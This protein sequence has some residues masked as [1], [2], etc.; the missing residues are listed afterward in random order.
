MHLI[1]STPWGSFLRDTTSREGQV[2]DRPPQPDPRQ[3][4]LLGSQLAGVEQMWFDL[5]CECLHSSGPF[6]SPHI[7]GCWIV[8]GPTRTQ[9]SRFTLTDRAAWCLM[10]LQMG[11][12]KPVASKTQSSFYSFVLKVFVNVAI[13]I[14][15]FF[16]SRGTLLAAHALGHIQASM[17]NSDEAIRSSYPLWPLLMFGKRAILDPTDPNPLQT[18]HLHCCWSWW[19]R[20]HSL[21]AASAVPG[22]GGLW[23]GCCTGAGNPQG[24]QH[25]SPGRLKPLIPQFLL[26]T[27]A[28]NT[29]H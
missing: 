22:R 8:H 10:F 15:F 2:W 25:H 19:Y 24:M 18:P 11:K 4:S 3:A 13:C 27:V 28:A 6:V 12:F 5:M 26:F 21:L 29:A 9:T 17:A 1:L 7:T 20:Q 23:C 16:S 14:F